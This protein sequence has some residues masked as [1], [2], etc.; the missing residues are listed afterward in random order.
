MQSF[1]IPQT[2]HKLTYILTSH[3]EWTIFKGDSKPFFLNFRKIILKI[4]KPPVPPLANCSYKGGG[5]NIFSIYVWFMVFKMTARIKLRQC[6]KKKSKIC[7]WGRVI[8]EKNYWFWRFG[9]F[10]QILMVFDQFLGPITIFWIFSF[11]I[12]LVWYVRSIWINHT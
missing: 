9:W 8:E 6:K 2:I 3:L 4:R 5:Q 12:V 10:E 7:W 1:W 11:C